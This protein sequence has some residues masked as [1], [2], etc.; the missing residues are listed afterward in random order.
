MGDFI[1]KLLPHRK[2]I[3][4]SSLCI[5]DQQG[6]MSREQMLS[7]I[8]QGAMSNP[9]GIKSAADKTVLIRGC[10]PVMAQRAGSFLPPLIGNATMV[11]CTNDND[12]LAKLQEK[13]YDVVMF[14]PGAC[15][16]DAANR[17]IPGRNVATKAWNLSRYREFVR[18]HQGKHV[19]IVE[20]TDERQIVPLLRKAL[21]I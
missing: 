19:P 10:D 20:T 4:L 14:A 16:W 3:V 2:S 13:R 9:H 18:S 12:F 6:N 8:K 11:A 21:G 15:R 7:E 17:P 5:Q 1:L